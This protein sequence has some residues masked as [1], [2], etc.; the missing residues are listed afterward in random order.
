MRRF[1]RRRNPQY[2]LPFLVLVGVGV[3]GVLG[4]QLWNLFFSVSK[5]NAYLYVIEG[6]AKAL[7]FGQ[8][9]WENTY[10]GAKI[11]LGDTIQVS[12]RGKAVI[13][14]YDGST[15]R[16]G[17]NTEVTLV[18]I[19]R[20]NE[21]EDTIL[22]LNQGFIWVN[23]PKTQDLKNSK[24]IIHTTYGSYNITGTIFDLEKAATETLRVLKGS[25][26]LDI[27]QRSGDKPRTI[28][29]IPVGIGQEVSL[30][31]A[32]MKAYFELQSPSV[33][34]EISESFKQSSWYIWNNE[35]D[36]NPVDFSKIA[37]APVTLPVVTGKDLV[38]S[39][40]PETP[41]V[42][43]TP[44]NPDAPTLE[45]TV[46]ISPQS[47]SAEFMGKALL[48]SGTAPVGTEKMM[49]TQLLAGSS[50]E[51]KYTLRKFDSLALT[52][53]YQ[54]STATDNIRSGNNTYTF[55]GQN[56]DG[57]FSPADTIAVS[58]SQVQPAV[59]DALQKPVLSTVNGKVYNEGMMVDIDGIKLTGTVAGAS[60]LL[61]NNYALSLF[62]AGDKTWTY[63]LKESL[64]NFEE[65][66][67]SY[68]IDAVAADGKKQTLSVTINYKK[69]EIV[70]AQ[71][72]E[73]VVPTTPIVEAV[74][75]EP[76]SS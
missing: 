53:S 74:V 2:L 61:V 55:Y 4:F 22:N 33:L 42:M 67:N 75:P 52:W 20:T 1:R 37:A 14:F 71:T 36:T 28:E 49:V 56:K 41:V 31:D 16:M 54:L 7:P 23:K 66:L 59:I 65:G 57:T 29:S 63:N 3:V 11:M 13:V 68:T 6:R 32:V 70:P 15:L 47:S 25:V 10:N 72:V 62:K 51:E 39:P 18:D 5:G 30:D 9:E 50:K 27:L 44:E 12:G 35:L 19:T 43:P 73:A 34:K 21:Y 60:K 38:T 26:R 64:G 46:I 58:S 40:V 24:F 45:A 48:I 8:K 17:D 69:A 76:V